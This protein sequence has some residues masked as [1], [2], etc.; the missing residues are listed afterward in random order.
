MEQNLWTILL[1]YSFVQGYILGIYALIKFKRSFL[2]MLLI[3]V[4]TL[5]WVHLY[6][7]FEWFEE[8]PH[9]IFLD[10]PVWYLIGPLFLLF[11]RRLFDKSTGLGEILLHFLPA[12]CFV[13]YLWP[14]LFQSGG[15]KVEVFKGVFAVETFSGDFNHYLFSTHILIYL[16]YSY[17]IFQKNSLSQRQENALSTLVFDRLAGRMLKY[18]LLFFILAFGFYLFT[19]LFYSWAIDYYEPFYLGLSALIHVTFYYAVLRQ[20][21][22][23]EADRVRMTSV[24]EKYQSSTLTPEELESIVNRVVQYVAHFD[25]YRN[26]ELRLRH[27]AEALNIPSHHISQAINITLRKTFFDV[28]NDQR[29]E[30]LKLHI[31]DE[32]YANYT[33]A[34]IA[35]EHGF[36]SPSSFYRIF[37]K[38]TG[39]TPREFMKTVFVSGSGRQ[40]DQ[41]ASQ[42]SSHLTQHKQPLV[43]RNPELR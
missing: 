14:F 6:Y 4:S 38:H 9:Y 33:L 28:V 43:S 36:K 34:A 10:A 8:Y 30:G 37:R 35:A 2:G 41:V 17:F 40:A 7:R 32:R 13:A 29:V 3:S 21:A 15:D 18:Y 23:D 31:S 1:T 42:Q 11:V 39:K 25:V 24:Q 12:M 19:D 5:I 26:P 27:V 16:A 22:P 20:M